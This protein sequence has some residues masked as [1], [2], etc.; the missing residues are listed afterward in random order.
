[1]KFYFTSSDP[2]K[3]NKHEIKWMLF[4]ALVLLYFIADVWMR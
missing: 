2:L 4:A 3:E 1:M